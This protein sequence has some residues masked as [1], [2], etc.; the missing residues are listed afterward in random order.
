MRVRVRLQHGDGV[1]RWDRVRV[2]DEDVVAARLRDPA[3][4]V[5][6]ES[7]GTL[8]LEHARGLGD[9]LGAP[10]GVLD[11]DELV[12]LGAQ[13]RQ[14]LPELRGVPVRDHDRRDRHRPSTSR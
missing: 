14:E 5:G 7:V 9:V 13:R 1:G 11:D 3:V 12:H 2:G 8:V 4:G 6:G 10:R